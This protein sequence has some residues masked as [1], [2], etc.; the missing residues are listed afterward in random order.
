MSFFEYCKCCKLNHNNKNY[1][2]QRTHKEKVEFFFKKAEKKIADIKFFMEDAINYRTD[3]ESEFWCSFC[4]TC[5]KDDKQLPW[6][7]LYV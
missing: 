4:G 1:K 3:Y 6:Y 5:T 2:F 7:S